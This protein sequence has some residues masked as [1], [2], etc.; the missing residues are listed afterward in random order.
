MNACAFREFAKSAGP[1]ST[2]LNRI[3]YTIKNLNQAH[4]D[5]ELQIRNTH[6]MT[7][8]TIKKHLIRQATEIYWGW[9]NI[10]HTIDRVNDDVM[11][12][13]F[14]LSDCDQGFI[15]I[16]NMLFHINQSYPDQRYPLG[17]L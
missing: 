10:K 11:D 9:E 8:P 4:R 1:S 16:T 7:D 6:S 12:K 17:R 15:Q 3:R 14:W 5:I 2:E 13:E